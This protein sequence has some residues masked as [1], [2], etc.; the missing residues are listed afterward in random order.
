MEHPGKLD[1]VN[2]SI[3]SESDIGDTHRSQNGR[4]ESALYHNRLAG[5]LPKE[6]L[7]EAGEDCPQQQSFLSCSLLSIHLNCSL[8]HNH[9]FQIVVGA[10][11]CASEAPG[12]FRC[13]PLRHHRRCL[14]ACRKYPP[15]EPTIFRSCLHDSTTPITVTNVD[16]VG[17][18][19]T[20]HSQSDSLMRA[21][22]HTS[23]TH[24]PTP[25]R[26]PRRS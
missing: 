5:S 13:S 21:S 17:R 15:G 26:R 10:P 9:A 2:E 19:M 4:A 14:C 18:R 24:P 3:D 20:S 12:S 8:L 16:F 23:S 1:V 11:D 7:P 25:C 6:L 22:R